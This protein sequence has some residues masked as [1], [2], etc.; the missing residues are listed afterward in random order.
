MP[1][2]TTP[3]GPFLCV[4]SGPGAVIS[5]TYGQNM[6]LSDVS[7]DEGTDSLP[8]FLSKRKAAIKSPT[9]YD[10][11][12]IISYKV[13]EVC[14]RYWLPKVLDTSSDEVWNEPIPY[15]NP[16]GNAVSDPSFDARVRKGIFPVKDTKVRESELTI[17][18]KA[19][20]MLSH[21]IARAR[22]VYQRFLLLLSDLESLEDLEIPLFSEARSLS[23]IHI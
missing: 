2:V 14:S 16:A 13:I 10:H 6:Y 11:H 12:T 15:P 21:T 3:P 4:R 5:P 9:F 23:L 7:G 17:P 22:A 1:I 8:A 19:A 18:L 20:W